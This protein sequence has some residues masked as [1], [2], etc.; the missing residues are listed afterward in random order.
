LYLRGIAMRAT[1]EPGQFQEDADQRWARVPV[2]GMKEIQTLA[3]NLGFVIDLDPKALA[4]V[5]RTQSL[6]QFT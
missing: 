4:R 1:V 6:L 2:L 3:E 5:E